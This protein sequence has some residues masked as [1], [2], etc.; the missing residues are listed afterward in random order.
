MASGSSQVGHFIGMLNAFLI[1]L[2]DGTPVSAV[3]R[4]PAAGDLK[5]RPANI[6]LACVK[7]PSYFAINSLSRTGDVLSR[8]GSS[9]CSRATAA[10]AR[11]K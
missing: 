10:E 1:P 4:Y 8:L 7:P 11:T 9:E 6:Y 2:L 5:H 3:Y